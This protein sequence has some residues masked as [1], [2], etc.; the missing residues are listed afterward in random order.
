MKDYILNYIANNDVATQLQ[1]SLQ[2]NL[3]DIVA[4]GQAYISRIGS[5]FISFVS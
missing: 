4:A 1:T 3:S 2:K 5:W